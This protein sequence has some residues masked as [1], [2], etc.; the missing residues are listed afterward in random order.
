MADITYT[1]NQDNPDNIQ[2]FEQFS[3]A[4]KNLVD[5]YAINSLFDSNKNTI[6]LNILSL[7]DE[8]IESIPGYTNYKLLGDAQSAGKSGSSIV[9]I[10]P[11]ED[12]KLYGYETGGVKVLYH[13]LNDLYS[14]DKT[15]VEHYIDSISPDRTELRLVSLDLTDSE[16]VSYTANVKQQLV[17][18]SYFNEF[19]LNFGNNDLLIGTNIDTVDLDN[20]KAVVVKL[21]EPLPITYDIKATLSIVE[22]ISDS[23]AYEVDSITQLPPITAN[24]LRPANFNLD[25]TDNQVIPTQYL[26]YNDLFSY[27]VNNT[28]NQ[29]YS[30]VSEKGAELSIDHTDYSNFVHF[31]SALALKELHLQSHT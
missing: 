9:T 24:T 18:Q 3:Q 11:V 15:T 6:E 30:L 21:Y 2:G 27:P 19:R 17:S 22:I 29:L 4:D 5:S 20:T 13:F 7:A 14:A 23:I 26:D 8:L 10:N 1:V 16:I 28:N 12:C 31:S 25:I